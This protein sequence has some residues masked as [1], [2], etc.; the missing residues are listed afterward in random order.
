MESTAVF[1]HHPTRQ[2]IISSKDMRLCMFQRNPQNMNKFVCKGTIH[3]GTSTAQRLMVYSDVARTLFT[4]GGTGA[5]YAWDIEKR[6]K[7]K[8]ILK[9]TKCINALIV[10]DSLKLLVSGGQDGKIYLWCVSYH[11]ICQNYVW[12]FFVVSRIIS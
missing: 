5:I 10:I 4:T 12:V 7:K 9:H 1:W 6:R 8:V 11:I 3:T 2:L